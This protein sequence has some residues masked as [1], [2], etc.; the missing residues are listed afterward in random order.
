[1]LRRRLGELWRALV[2]RAVLRAIVP[3]ALFVSVNWLVF[4]YAVVTDRV[5]H[6]SLGYFLNP[7]VSIVL[8]LVFLRERMRPW[9]WFA[10]AI[11]TLGVV[12]MA[13]L[14]DDLP[15]I[16]LVLAL[17]FGLYGLT[18]KVAPIDGLLGATIESV[19]LLPIAIGYLVWIA[20]TGEGAFGSLGVRVDLLLVCTG[21]VT[22]APL[23]WFANAARLL[24]LRTLG[25]VQ[26]LA[27][28]C[29]FVLAVLVFAEPLTDVHLRAFACIWAAVAVFTAE[30]WWHGRR[31][32]RP[33]DRDLG[34]E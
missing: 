5:L 10:V 17:S 8:G 11:A 32:V 30:S 9:Q 31:R 14:A 21:I 27:P 16:G 34:E 25:F 26:Y 24:P 33:S 19:L 2:Q 7:L 6:A 22:G 23:V 1:V 12:Q 15:W 4:V 18:R 20:A 13:T 29:Q 3:A 28:S